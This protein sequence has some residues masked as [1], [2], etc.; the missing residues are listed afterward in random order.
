[1]NVILRV[2]GLALLS[3][4]LVQAPKAE[5]QMRYNYFSVGA[6]I[7]TAHYQGDLDDDGFEFWKG[8]GNPF[9]NQLFRPSFGAHI[10]YHF[11]KHM[12]A[13]LALT[14]GWIGAADSLAS[15]GGRQDRNLH[16]RSPM[17]EASVQVM[18]EFFATSRFYNYR[19]IWTPYVFTGLSVFS[20]QSQSAAQ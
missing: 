4:A 19:P 1:M 6:H 20:L 14:H 2:L 16:F 18:Y 8:N 11:S 13:R 9:S 5:A 17:S 10:N 12:I 15:S 3:A 7:G